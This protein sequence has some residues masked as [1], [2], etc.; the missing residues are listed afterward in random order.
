MRLTNPLGI[1]CSL[2]GHSLEYKTTFNSLGRHVEKKSCTR[3][4]HEET[5][6]TGPIFPGE[7]DDSDRAV[8]YIEQ[9][10]HRDPPDPD[11]PIWTWET[12]KTQQEVLQDIMAMNEDDLTELI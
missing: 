11:S 5:A 6:Y 9:N 7:A 2:R 8:E 12:D 4:E 1:L 3:C 10:T